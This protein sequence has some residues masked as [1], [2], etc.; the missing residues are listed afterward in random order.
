MGQRQLA[1]LGI[2]RR[3]PVLRRSAGPRLHQPRLVGKHHRL[4]PVPQ[5]ELGQIR[6]TCV[7]TVVLHGAVNDG[8]AINGTSDLHLAARPGERVRLRLVNAVAPGM[9]GGPEAPAL[10]RAPCRVVA[11]D[12]RDLNQPQLLGPQ[13]LPLGMG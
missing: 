12:G 4:H 1:R 3:R 6:A 2:R 11:L 7:F 13:L 5:P 10:I 9:D 8:V